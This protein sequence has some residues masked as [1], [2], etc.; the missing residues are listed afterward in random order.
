MPAPRL[1][2]LL[3]PPLSMSLQYQRRKTAVT[4]RSHTVNNAGRRDLSLGGFPAAVENSA[5]AL[6]VLTAAIPPI[7]YLEQ[8]RYPARQRYG[9]NKLVRKEPTNRSRLSQP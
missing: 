5:I 3:G 8:Q 9:E 2:G 7:E 1:V 6:R 4:K